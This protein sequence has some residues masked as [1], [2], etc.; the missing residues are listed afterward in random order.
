MGAINGKA[1]YQKLANQATLHAVTKTLS[2]QDDINI[3]IQGEEATYRPANDTAT[4]TS[5][6]L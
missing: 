5:T 6:A 1:I 4:T 3:N 2:M